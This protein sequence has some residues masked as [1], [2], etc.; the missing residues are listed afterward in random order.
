MGMNII[1]LAASRIGTEFIPFSVVFDIQYSPY[2]AVGEDGKYM[3][4]VW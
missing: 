3:S 1:M 4:G 2:A